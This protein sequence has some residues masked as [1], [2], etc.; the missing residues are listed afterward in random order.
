MKF[1]S[2]FAQECY[3]LAAMP[4]LGICTVQIDSVSENSGLDVWDLG[5][6][7]RLALSLKQKSALNRLHGWL[8]ETPASKAA[9]GFGVFLAFRV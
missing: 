7:M 2:P 9:L 8:K 4:L 5:S 3:H 1:T 6:A